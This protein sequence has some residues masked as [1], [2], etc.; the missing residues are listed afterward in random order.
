[1]AKTQRRTCP[2]RQHHDVGLGQ[3]S[4]RDALY[5]ACPGYILNTPFAGTFSPGRPPGAPGWRP[6]PTVTPAGRSRPLA[7]RPASCTP[8]SV[9]I[10]V[11][12]LGLDEMRDSSKGHSNHYLALTGHN[13]AAALSRRGN[14]LS[15]IR[16]TISH[17]HA[18]TSQL[19]G[20]PAICE[21]HRLGAIYIDQQHPLIRNVRPTYQAL[22]G[23][24]APLGGTTM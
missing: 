16:E 12:E 22:P 5:E 21:S 6:W 4:V 20:L 17:L 1:M 2:P 14:P 23:L 18:R 13:P 11:P 8:R 24:L 19:P 9:R 7:A 10:T 3:Y 15:R